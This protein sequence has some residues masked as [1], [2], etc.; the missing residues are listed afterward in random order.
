MKVE[1]S[2]FYKEINNLSLSVG[3]WGAIF[4]TL[5]RYRDNTVVITFPTA[6]WYDR[7]SPLAWNLIYFIVI[8][9]Q[10]KPSNYVALLVSF[11]LPLFICLFTSKCYTL[12]HNFRWLSFT[13]IYPPSSLFNK[14]FLM[15]N[16]SQWVG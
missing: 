14:D 8:N 9:L 6:V 3:S 16:R 12:S 15:K 2:L 13:N 11:T 5:T 10:I 1:F 7:H 4:W